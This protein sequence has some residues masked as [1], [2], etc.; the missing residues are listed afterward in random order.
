MISPP[1]LAGGYVP[2]AFLT[3][4]VDPLILTSPEGLIVKLPSGTAIG[5]SGEKRITRTEVAGLKGTVKESAGFQDWQISISGTFV[6]PGYRLGVP[7]IPSIIQQVR[8]LNALFRRESELTV[9][10]SKLN[11]LQISSVIM[12]RLDLP[13]A[14]SAY[15]QPF[16]INL[17]SDIALDLDQAGL[18]AKA[19]ALGAVL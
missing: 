15:M 7:G 9:T 3:D 18:D 14:P 13:D 12:T 8:Q 6:A 1:I 4:D 19:E 5:V 10:N 11:A 2:P 16:S 17:E